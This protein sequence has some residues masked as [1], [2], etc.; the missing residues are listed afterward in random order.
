MIGMLGCGASIG[1]ALYNSIFTFNYVCLEIYISYGTLIETNFGYGWSG[2]DNLP[3][4]I[5][6]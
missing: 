4:L 1:K 6:E 2:T 5:R 3:S